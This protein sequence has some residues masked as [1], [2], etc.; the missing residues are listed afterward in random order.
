MFC[1]P[2]DKHTNEI[3]PESEL[4]NTRIGK[5]LILDQD[6]HWSQTWLAII[7]SECQLDSSQRVV[8]KISVG[9]VVRQFVE[10]WDSLSSDSVLLQLKQHGAQK[11]DWLFF[12]WKRERKNTDHSH[13]KAQ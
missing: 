7:C 11:Y 13:Q 4:E 3:N 12:V 1:A 9:Y 5:Q 2:L 8:F 10:V 6:T